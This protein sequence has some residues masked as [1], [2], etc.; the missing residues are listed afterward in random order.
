[1]RGPARPAA[2][3]PTK[4]QLQLALR[5]LRRPGWPGTLEECLAKPHFALALR[6]LAQI[7]NRGP[8]GCGFAPSAELPQATPRASYIAARLSRNPSHHDWKALQA[9][10]HDD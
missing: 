2:A 4:Q 1:M 5:H 3:E 10:K 6:A 8:A 9:G 7:L